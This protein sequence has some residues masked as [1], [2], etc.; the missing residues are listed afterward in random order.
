MERKR[1]EGIKIP[2]RRLLLEVP[3]LPA[4]KLS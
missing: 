3:K 4:W 2:L 1:V